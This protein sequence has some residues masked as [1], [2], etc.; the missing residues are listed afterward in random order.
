[1]ASLRIL[2][3]IEAWMGDEALVIGGPRQLAL[4]AYLVLSPNRAVSSDVVSDAVWNSSRASSGNRLQM[5][6]ARL[7]QALEPLS[8]SGIVRLRTVKGGYMLEVAPGELDADVFG[9]GIQA[10]R[11]ALER[12]DAAS[13]V[14][15]LSDALVLWRGSPLAE[16]AFADFAL[17]EIRRLHELRMLALEARFDAELAL[18]RHTHVIGELEALGLEEPTRERLAGLLMLALYRCGRQAEA[19]EVFQRV[20]TNLADE[21]GLEP[22]PALRALQAQILEQAPSLSLRS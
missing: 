1:M 7:R 9:D 16:V 17:S 20:R 6:V 2:G 22:G 5:A 11:N 13:A 19:L 12:G 18:G 14:T 10:G 3:Q 15:L 4:L 21:L 8:E